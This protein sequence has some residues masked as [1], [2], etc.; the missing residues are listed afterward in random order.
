MVD[1][2]VAAEDDANARRDSERHGDG[3]DG[4]AG[5]AERMVDSILGPLSSDRADG[6][7]SDAEREANDAEQRPS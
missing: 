2:D 7:D 6:A 4:V 3:D 5:T 1:R